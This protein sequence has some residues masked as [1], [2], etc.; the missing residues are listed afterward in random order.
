MKEIRD[1]VTTL[2]M[3]PLVSFYFDSSKTQRQIFTWFAAE[4]GLNIR[5][6][7]SYKYLPCMGVYWD[8]SKWR[9]INNIAW[10]GDE[11][12][13]FRDITGNTAFTAWYNSTDTFNGIL[14]GIVY[15]PSTMNRHPELIYWPGINS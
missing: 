13:D 7:G 5:Q 3:T 11:N 8:G 6:G 4:N 10:D 14:E 12:I 1:N 9:E 2:N 15:V